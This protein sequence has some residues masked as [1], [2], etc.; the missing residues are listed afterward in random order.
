MARFEEH[1][2]HY[3]LVIDEILKFYGQTF[4]SLANL[5]S[6]SSLGRVK[7]EQKS[8]CTPTLLHKETVKV[9]TIQKH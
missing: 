2:N 3:W 9:Y 4:A 5:A 7:K 1:S 6:Y 8:N